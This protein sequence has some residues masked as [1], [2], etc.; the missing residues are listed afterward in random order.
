MKINHLKTTLRS[1]GR[2]FRYTALHIIG[3]GVAIGCG[4]FIY[5]YITFHNSYDNYH[6]RAQH[7]YKLV[8]DLLL[9]ETSYNEGASYAIYEALK[10]NVAG[11]D[12]AAFAMINQDLTIR[13]NGQLFDSEKKGA[14]AASDWFNLFDYHW[15]AG[16]PEAL[17]QPNTV[18]L[19]ASTAARFFG[20]KDPMG[21]L[22]SV[23]E[24]PLKVVGVLAD[25]PSNTSLK[26]AFYISE[27]SIKNVL[28]G[29][30]D[31]FFS[32]WG[33]LN[34]TNQVYISL[35]EGT[36]TAQVEKT[37]RAMTLDTF[38]EETG[39]LFKF[40]LLPLTDMH[41][42]GRY[43]G[44]M[45]KSLLIILAIIGTA[46][47]L[48]A[49]L[50]YVNL[51]IAQYARRSSE[52]G[53]RKVLGSSRWQL[54]MQL[55]TESLVVAAL[56]TLFGIALVA[57]AIPLANNY[58]F[59][60]EPVLLFSTLQL[61][62]SAAVAW[63]IIGF[64]AG[65][66]PA[67]TIGK[68]HAL[69]AIRQQVGFGKPLGRRL[70]VVIQN[71]LSICLVLAT[72]VIMRQVHYLQQTDI[73]FDRESVIMLTLPKG[74]ANDS[75]W[76]SFL[77]AQPGVTA[78]SY[79]FRSPANHD[80]RGGTLRFDTRPDWETWSAKTTFADSA[81]VHA[82]GIQ[83]LAGRNIRSTAAVHE[84]LINE[85]MANQ[86][87]FDNLQDVVGKSLV[88][89][90]I[91]GDPGIIVGVV[92]NY[93]IH[94]LR[95]TIEPTVLG[96]NEQFMQSL[97]IKTNG[98]D[99]AAFVSQLEEE[100][101]VRYAGSLFQYQF[102]DNQIEQLYAAESIQ[103]QL[104]WIAASVAI[105]ISCLGLFG[106][107]SLGVQQRTK[108]IGIRKVLGASV[109]GIATLLSKDF[110]KL[111]MIALAVASPIAWWAMNK[112]LE[113]FAYRIDIEWW[114]FALAGVVVLAIAVLTISWQAI[115]AA[116]A[117]PVESLR[118]E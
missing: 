46:V 115:R 38:G 1:L 79:C 48:M 50:N 64:A 88:F 8:S 59:P 92:G 72:I 102:V 53:T 74:H 80:Q 11:V 15:L 111:M 25:E 76:R 104:I 33:Y 30:E 35:A 18:V 112:W 82:F 99:V 12:Q 61:I 34:S 21:A 108:E 63:L 113:G 105:L 20:S 86:L 2:N 103:Q 6:N 75:H 110:V 62:I 28:T 10:T 68:I 26:N 44:T 17:N 58:L 4:L 85:R 43:G 90:G 70:M 14:F 87:G 32:D 31:G 91:D 29:L 118:D 106:L 94:T 89:G 101:K 24:V 19:T 117:N 39:K 3:L 66:Y 7:T 47:L 51:S 16:K 78:Y 96:Y 45:Q 83:L 116:L 77:D 52:F 41:F 69:Q 84:Y 23:G 98:Q 13:V 37:L 57:I 5:R 56:A 95:Q 81:Y 60:M 22:I 36:T 114:M 40:S 107:I 65:I 9:E 93:N 109:S 49:L 42:N 73:G 27:S 54:F 67:W 71:T 100:W 97:A 55:I